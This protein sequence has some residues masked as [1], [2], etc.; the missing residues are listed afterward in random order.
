MF[1]NDWRIRKPAGAGNGYCLRDRRIRGVR[2]AP[3]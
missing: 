2:I 3:P 1:A